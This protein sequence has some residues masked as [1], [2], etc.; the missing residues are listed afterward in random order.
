MCIQTTSFE[1]R[2]ADNNSSRGIVR[3]CEG[4]TNLTTLWAF[5]LRQIKTMAAKALVDA[6]QN[7]Q[8]VVEVKGV[9]NIIEVAS[10]E[11]HWLSFVDI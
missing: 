8:S 2:K 11:R 9:G 3:D 6:S 7:L 5:I 10:Q 1:S 4:A